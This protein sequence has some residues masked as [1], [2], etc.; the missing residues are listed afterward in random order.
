MR[1][2]KLVVVVVGALFI[3]CSGDTQ[4]GIQAVTRVGESSVYF[5]REVRGQNFD[6]MG[7]SLNSE[8]CR[9]LDSST[10][11]VFAE[12]GPIEIFCR[13]QPGKLVVYATSP[14]R[15]P[16]RTTNELVVETV[17]LTPSAFRDLQATYRDRGLVKV[18]V[19]DVRGCLY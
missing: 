5:K 15:L 6:Q 14:L 7:I 18:T 19:D 11:Y 10:D 9:P 2:D 13:P 12:L 8:R 17:L 4:R 16:A 3:A 1:L